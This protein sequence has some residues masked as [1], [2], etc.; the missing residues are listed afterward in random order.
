MRFVRFVATA[1]L[2]LTFLCMFGYVIYDAS[3]G[4]NVLGKLKKPMLEFAKFPLCI[5][6]VLSSN[7]VKNIPPDY[8]SQSGDFKEV[9]KL[10]KDVFGLNAFYDQTEKQFSVKLFNFRDGEVKR[11]WVIPAEI[12]SLE[13]VNRNFANSSP[14]NPILM[15][16]GSI[17]ADCNRTP[18]LFRID[19]DGNVVWHNTEKVFHHSMNLD[20]DGH[21]WVCTAAKRA[22]LTFESEQNYTYSDD[23]ITQIDVETG[24]VLYDYSVS[25][26]LIDNNM[27]YLIYGQT[28]TISNSDGNDPLHLNDIEPCHTD[29]PYWQKGDLFLSLR[30]RS[31]ILL[32]RPTSGK[33]LRVIQGPF[34]SQHDVD[35]IS[36]HEI[37]F[38]NNN[39]TSLGTG[40]SE[41]IDIDSPANGQDM[42]LYSTITRYDMGDSAFSTF[43]EPIFKSE[44]IFTRTQGLFQFIDSETVFVECQN[45]GRVYVLNEEGVVMSKYMKTPIK[46]WI[47]RPH[48]IRIYNNLNFLQ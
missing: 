1:V 31:T 17:L 10:D 27:G 28:N 40:Q 12:V 42:F 44:R 3:T 21:L 16:D 38:F 18:N 25:K 46:G 41:G 33:V 8:I 2:I 5:K 43:A 26:L 48:W 19:K 36:E 15:P 32:Y 22:V 4:G 7:E 14:L 35:I 23:A 20:A 13:G 39:Y 24:A 47:E 30:N 34:L 9:N 45:D 29:G 6:E 11:Q 37:A